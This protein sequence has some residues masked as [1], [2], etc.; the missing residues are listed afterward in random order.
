MTHRDETDQPGSMT[1]R[2]SLGTLGTL[3]AGAAV[4]LAAPAVLAQEIAYPPMSISAIP[5]C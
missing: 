3:G 1:R 2:Q 4:V 5:T